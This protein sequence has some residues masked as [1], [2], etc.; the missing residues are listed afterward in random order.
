MAEKSSVNFNNVPWV[1]VGAVTASIAVLALS[2]KVINMA[3]MAGVNLLG[4]GILGGVTLGLVSAIPMLSERWEV[5][6]LKARKKHARENQVET[7]QLALKKKRKFVDQ[8]R[9]AVS[10]LNGQIKSLNDMVKARRQERP[11]EDLSSHEN[12]IKA[13]V[14]VSQ[15]ITQ[16]YHNAE[17]ALSKFEDRIETAKFDSKFNDALEIAGQSMDALGGGNI[18]DKLLEDEAFD[19][20]RDELNQSMAA[21]ELRATQLNNNQ[22]L[23]I[24]NVGVDVSGIT[25]DMKEYSHVLENR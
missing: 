15:Q 5:A 24:G 6:L 14:A 23:Q 12:K 21:L 9:N 10:A 22:T 16:E 20:L 4:L 19:S 18:M 13:M 7:L 2:Y 11:N 8:F 3:L 25:I 1:R 17:A